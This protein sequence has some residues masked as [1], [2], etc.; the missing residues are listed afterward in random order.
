MV[1]HP[2]SG[3]GRGRWGLTADFR[4]R[5]C[6]GKTFMHGDCFHPRLQCQC[7]PSDPALPCPALAA[8]A[9][10]PF[11]C[12]SSTLPPPV[13]SIRVRGRIQPEY[14]KRGYGTAALLPCWRGRRALCRLFLSTYGAAHAY[15]LSRGNSPTPCCTVKHNRTPELRTSKGA[16]KGPCLGPSLPEYAA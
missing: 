8:V 10:E 15:C 14:G 1:R 7:G 11:V 4:T 2:C 5:A 3:A 6:K 9:P 12:K 13:V 16:S